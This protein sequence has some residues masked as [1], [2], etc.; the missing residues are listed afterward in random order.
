MMAV[1]IPTLLNCPICGKPA[2]MR[3]SNSMNHIECTNGCR[4]PKCEHYNPRYTATSWN[5]WA[6]W[7]WEKQISLRELYDGMTAIQVYL[8]ERCQ[9]NALES[10]DQKD[11]KAL[12]ATYALQD[13]LA[14]WLAELNGP[15]E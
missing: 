7:Y 6:K 11:A 15:G 1:M 4:A 12:T 14:G 2:R 10:I 13:L 5:N 3:C 9:G 8:A